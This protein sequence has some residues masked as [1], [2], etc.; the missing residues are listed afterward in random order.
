M[1][2]L[3]PFQSKHNTITRAGQS[4]LVCKSKPNPIE[5]EAE[6]EVEE[7][8]LKSWGK[9]DVVDGEFDVAFC[10]T[11]ELD[12]AMVFTI[13][14]P[15]PEACPPLLYFIDQR[16]RPPPPPSILNHIKGVKKKKITTNNNSSSCSSSFTPKKISPVSKV[17]EDGPPGPYPS[18]YYAVLDDHLYSVGGRDPD[19]S[20]STITDVYENYTLSPDSPL[21]IVSSIPTTEVWMLDLKCPGKGWERAP[22]MKYRRQNPQTIVVDGKLYVFGGLGWLQP[23]DTFS[24]WMEVYDPKLRTWET[25]PN[26]PTYSKI[27]MDVI[28]AHSS[29]KGKDQII[30]NG[31]PVL[32]EGDSNGKG[33]YIA[34]DV[35][36]LSWNHMFH[37][38]H[39][40]WAEEVQCKRAQV[41]STTLYWTTLLTE[42]TD[43]IFIYGYNAYSRG[44]TR[45]KVN[46]RSILIEGED[47]LPTGPGFLHLADFK[48]CLLLFSYR[49]P[50]YYL[51]CLIFDL[52]G[53]ASNT[54]ILSVQKYLLDSC[55]QFLDCMIIETDSDGP[56]RSTY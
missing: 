12:E 35:I 5:A 1:E 56:S 22:S 37:E 44:W 2:S 47:F 20:A 38:A 17:A 8:L 21:N 10:T 14:I 26:P 6:W 27:D 39:L 32:E 31:P 3:L 34:Y 45:R 4:V 52:Y 40:S 36:S 54:S 24:G 13:K 49:R 48:F 55:L 33:Y 43:M 23:K 30:I 15:D 9:V 25:L 18:R 29:F 28:F 50:H 51:N 53:E 11:S 41:V 16:P 46:I 19:F 7:E 42:Y